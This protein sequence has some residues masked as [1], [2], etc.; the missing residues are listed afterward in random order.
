M[1]KT[2]IVTV[3][4]VQELQLPVYI[5]LKLG[6]KGEE[7]DLELGK[8]EEVESEE[9]LC[10]EFYSDE[11]MVGK[12][13]WEVE[14]VGKVE[15]RWLQVSRTEQEA[16]WREGVEEGETVGP[17]VLLSIAPY[18]HPPPTSDV[19][20]S[21]D[22]S[23]SSSPYLSHIPSAADLPSD[24]LFHLK[25]R[26][27]DLEDTL[28]K[29][30]LDFQVQ[31]NHQNTQFADKIAKMRAEI[32]EKVQQID[33]LNAQLSAC[34]GHISSLSFSNRSFKSTI[35]DLEHQLTQKTHKI[36]SL[37]SEIGEKSEEMDKM[38][39]EIEKYNEEKRRLERENV[40]DLRQTIE[41]LKSALSVSSIELDSHKAKTKA[42]EATIQDLQAS[43]SLVDQSSHPTDLIEELVQHYSQT[44]A[45]PV[46]I[47]RLVD[48][49]YS[50]GAKKVVLCVKDGE[51]GIKA[52]GGVMALEEFLKIY[53][54]VSQS[55]LH[56]P[57]L[58][59]HDSFRRSSHDS[60]SPKPPPLPIPLPSH[61]HTASD[62]LD[63]RPSTDRSHI[64]KQRNCRE[65]SPRP[66]W[67]ETV[68]SRSKASAKTMKGKEDR[69]AGR[70]VWATLGLRDS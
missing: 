53:A 9:T 34:E 24:Q 55:V 57:R 45:L 44:H 38:R 10:L 12:T 8:G 66:V 15:N 39:R 50:I 54:P 67:R 52:A 49:K 70:G 35:T 60:P 47:V 14:E 40:C 19:Y 20:L 28:E 69:K 62:H 64:L 1:K 33:E 42:Y 46:P 36:E 32:Q 30:R 11:G 51:L 4:E 25:Q 27:M 7:R 61:T 26:V 17:R 29:E 6:L 21:S 31:I 43:M 48:G 59:S 13:Q 5:K 22:C 56:K 18:D 41:S 63:F 37:I 16:R 23:L 65:V 68:S 58:L 2:L 3:C